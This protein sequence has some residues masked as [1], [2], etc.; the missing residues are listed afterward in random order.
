[1]NAERRIMD[2]FIHLLGGVDDGEHHKAE[3]ID[4]LVRILCGCPTV[5]MVNPFGASRPFVYEGLGENEEYRVFVA[6]YEDGEDGPDTYSWV[7]D[8]EEL[9]QREEAAKTF[10]EG[11]AA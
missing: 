9:W 10:Q 3:T 2:A 5:P 6:S 8:H 7:V 4:H 11:G 1:M